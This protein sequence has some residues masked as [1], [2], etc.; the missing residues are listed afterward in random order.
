MVQA[1]LTKINAAEEDVSQSGF[2][3]G[4]NQGFGSASER[5]SSIRVSTLKLLLRFVLACLTAIATIVLP[6]F[7]E[8]RVVVSLAERA[9]AIARTALFGLIADQASKFLV[10]HG[11]GL[12]FSHKR[13]AITSWLHSGPS[14][15]RNQV[16]RGTY[17]GIVLHGLL[18]SLTHLLRLC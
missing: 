1:A 5:G 7:T 9:V 4:N 8:P 3:C 12:A 2:V 11:E 13:R 17:A 14:R 16:W 18:G 6:V 15:T 10:G